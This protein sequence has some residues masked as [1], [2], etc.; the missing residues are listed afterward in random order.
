MLVLYSEVDRRGIFFWYGDFV[1]GIMCLTDVVYEFEFVSTFC[2]MVGILIISVVFY[3]LW[4]VGMYLDKYFLI[5][6]V[7]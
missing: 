4:V 2:F 5:M 6:S 1:L 3:F 7:I